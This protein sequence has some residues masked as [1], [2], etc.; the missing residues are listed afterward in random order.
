LA[1]HRPLEE[2]K[3]IGSL[4]QLLLVCC[5]GFLLLGDDSFLF[6]VC[7][8]QLAYTLLR[9]RQ[10][11]GKRWTSVFHVLLNSRHRHWFRWHREFFCDGVMH[12]AIA[13]DAA[14]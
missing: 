5:D 14:R 4:R 13:G 11:I 7:L 9:G 2:P 12:A 8:F 6:R 1:E 3:L 10:L